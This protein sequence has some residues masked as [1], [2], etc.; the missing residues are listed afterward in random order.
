MSERTIFEN[1]HAESNSKDSI[2][3]PLYFISLLL[4]QILKFWWVSKIQLDLNNMGIYNQHNWI[5]HAYPGG[6]TF[7]VVTVDITPLLSDLLKKLD[8]W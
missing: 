7:V 6:L 5:L 8:S 2:T 4:W 1:G 3:L